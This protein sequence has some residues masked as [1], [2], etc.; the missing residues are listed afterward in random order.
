MGGI[1]TDPWAA[2][3]PMAAPAV[4]RSTLDPDAITR[5]AVIGMWR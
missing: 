4:G 2:A 3:Q 1:L 5:E